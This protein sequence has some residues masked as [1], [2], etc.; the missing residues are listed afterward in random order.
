MDSLNFQH[1][2][3]RTLD[4]IFEAIE[5]AGEVAAKLIIL[6]RHDEQAMLLLHDLIGNLCVV[7]MGTL[8]LQ[9]HAAKVP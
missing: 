1:T 3:S 5:D 6:A 4:D 9:Q 7:R 8:I 2:A